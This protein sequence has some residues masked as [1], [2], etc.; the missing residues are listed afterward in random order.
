LCQ[1][2]HFATNPR[3]KTFFSKPLQELPVVALQWQEK[4][5]FTTAGFPL[6]SGAVT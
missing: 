5:G 6:H 1:I 2:Q 4:I 3:A